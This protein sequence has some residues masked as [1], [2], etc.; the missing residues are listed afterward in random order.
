MSRCMQL[1]VIVKPFYQPDFQAAF[2][3]LAR[4]L[5]Y[6]NPALAAGNPSL[7]EL[8]GRLDHLLYEFDGTPVREVLL[9]YR[10]K[11][12]AL[13]KEIEDHIAGRR[14]SQADTLLYQ[15]E[16]IFDDVERQLA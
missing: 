14:L 4:Q 6:L 3:N 13:H 16:D 12:L 8:A 1:T 9:P 7:Y 11:I 15:L 5:S 2:P 10:A